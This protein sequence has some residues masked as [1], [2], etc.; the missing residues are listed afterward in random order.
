MS[1]VLPLLLSTVAVGGLFGQ[2][3]AQGSVEGN[4]RL[5]GTSMPKGVQATTTFQKGAAKFV[6]S[7][8]QEGKTVVL[9]ATGGYTLKG[10][11]LTL[12]FTDAKVTSKDFTPAQRKQMESPQMRANMKRG[13][14]QQN[15]TGRVKFLG[16][17]KFVMTEKNGKTTTFT[18]VG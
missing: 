10:D 8:L 4:W 18:R 16:R 17:N 14:S 13:A 2:A 6:L 7:G 5:T 11:L 12:R 9:T 1:R 15:T 3:H